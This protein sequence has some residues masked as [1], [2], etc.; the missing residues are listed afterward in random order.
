VL[1]VF[2]ALNFT[3]SPFQRVTGSD[4]SSHSGLQI[5]AVD[6]VTKEFIVKRLPALVLR[7]RW[8]GG[9]AAQSPG[10]QHRYGSSSW[11]LFALP[12]SPAP[13]LLHYRVYTTM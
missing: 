6:R 9:S 4:F 7:Q 2:Q 10:P 3:P 1:P 5:A 11:P 13:R 8:G 12:L